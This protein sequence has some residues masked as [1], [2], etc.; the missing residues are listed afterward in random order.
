MN[1]QKIPITSP[2]A[3]LPL[4]NMDMDIAQKRLARLQEFMELQ[5]IYS[6]AIKEVTTKLEILDEEFHTRYDHNPIHRIEK[7][8]KSLP[9]MASKLQSRGLPLDIPSI[10]NELYDVAGVR[11][12]CNYCQDI[13]DVAEIL[14][15]QPDI[16]LIRSRDYI[17]APKPNGYRSLHLV[18]EVPV[19]LS[20]GAVPT[21][22][23]IQ[24]R[25]IAMDFWASL[26]HKLHYK[27]DAAITDD[28][29]QEL[30][31][32]ADVSADLDSRMQAIFN[33]ISAQKSESSI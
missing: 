30:K 22:V 33:H 31:H 10:K 26:E 29:W 16:R 24:L 3:T 18:V 19:F 27:S 32:C 17:K 7:R 14:T 5:Q 2:D 28:L 1:E 13:Y 8:L 21:P 25:T 4:P 6:G 20:T 9:S 11:V 15:S 12:I 23:E